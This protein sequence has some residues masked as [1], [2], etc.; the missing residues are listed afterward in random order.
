MVDVSGDCRTLGA[1]VLECPPHTSPPLVGNFTNSQKATFAQNKPYD[2]REDKPKAK[3]WS[4]KDFRELHLICL[5]H[6]EIEIPP[7]I[8][9]LFPKSGQ[10]NRD[11]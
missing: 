2:A 8:C 5:G 9:L 6:P 10:S 7:S 11:D 4:T 1:G 3:P